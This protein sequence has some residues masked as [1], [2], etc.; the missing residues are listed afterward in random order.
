MSL[1][2]L[3]AA[4]WP[5]AQALYLSLTASDAIGNTGDF[6]RVLSHP[7]TQVIGRFEGEAL[8]AM[9]TLHV[10][11]NLTYGGQPY[12]LVENVVTAPEHRG[13]GHGRAVLE[14]LLTQA[15]EAG[16]YKVMLLT[17]QGR[18]ARGFYEAIGFS[19]KEKWGMILRY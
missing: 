1:R 17:G 12:A 4:D 3:I 8:L 5:Q 13:R 10:L 16:C 15:R 11:P 6:D 7:G 18:T 19:A 9:A 2:A 14:H